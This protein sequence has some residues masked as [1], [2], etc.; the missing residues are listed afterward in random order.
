MYPFHF[1]MLSVPRLGTKPEIF[2]SIIYLLTL[3]RWATALWY[4]FHIFLNNI[5]SDKPID[6]VACMICNDLYGSFHFGV[7]FIPRLGPKPSS[8]LSFIF[9]HSY[10]VPQPFGYLFHIILN[11]I[12]SDKPIE[13]VVCTSYN[14][15]YES[16]PFWSTFCP[17]AGNRTQDLC[18][19]HFFSH[20]CPLCYRPFDILWL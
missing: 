5:G 12:R 16:L 14:D 17:Q 8:Y 6:T 18:V 19:L 3:F 13:T 2:L 7:L 10:A 4:L 20:T 11:N 15:L 1:G 9:S